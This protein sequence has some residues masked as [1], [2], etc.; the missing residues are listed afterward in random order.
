MIMELGPPVPCESITEY[1]PPLKIAHSL[2]IANKGNCKK[3]LA[4]V[5]QGKFG[6]QR[7]SWRMRE[8]DF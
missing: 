7:L 5:L 1:R 6:C 3:I 8:L 2:S 4:D